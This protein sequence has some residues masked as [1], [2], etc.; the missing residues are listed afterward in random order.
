MNVLRMSC[1][2]YCNF[3]AGLAHSQL[4]KVAKRGVR[5]LANLS[6]LHFPRA[7]HINAELCPLFWPKVVLS[8]VSVGN[9]HA[10]RV[11]HTVRR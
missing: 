4:I 5:S 3:V 10:M 11:I 6:Y 9:G 7:I 2:R 8:E 1:S